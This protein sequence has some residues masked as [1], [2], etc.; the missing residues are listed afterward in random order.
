MRP[1]HC[2]IKCD[3]YSNK[4]SVNIRNNFGIE[5]GI[6]VR[7]YHSFFICFNFRNNNGDFDCFNDRCN[8]SKY[9]RHNICNINSK[10]D[11]HDHT[12][13]HRFIDSNQ[14]RH[15]VPVELCYH[16]GEQHCLVVADHQ[17]NLHSHFD[18]SN[19][20]NH[21]RDYWL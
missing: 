21:L 15:N 5:H 12:V 13:Q 10:F 18:C 3:F 11:C 19:C 20:S 16:I 2:H 7:K 14:L 1:N 9:Y 8:C 4:Y 17:C 6:V